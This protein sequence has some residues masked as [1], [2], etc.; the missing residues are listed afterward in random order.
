MTDKMQSKSEVLQPSIAVGVL[1]KNS[2]GEIFLAQSI[3]KWGG[4]W[5]V[6]GGHLEYGE[7]LIQCA[8]REVFEELGVEV[9][10]VQFFQVQE[11]TPPIIEYYKPD[12]HFIFINVSARLVDDNAKIV[13]QNSELQEY[14][15]IKP[16]DALEKL[17][18]NRSTR[19]LIEQSLKSEPGLPFLRAEGDN[20]GK[21]IQ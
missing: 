19:K 8:K 12:K 9:M 16:A 4:L 1:I 21:M 5:I 18:L 7:T 3:N 6:P 17:N 15:F 11:I 10:D 13:L 14:C 20:K 2:L